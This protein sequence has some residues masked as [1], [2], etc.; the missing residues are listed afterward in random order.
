MSDVFVVTSR[1]RQ[2]SVVVEI[3]CRDMQAAESHIKAQGI[4]HN[5][6]ITYDTP[7]CRV[8]ETSD[9]RWEVVRRAF[10]I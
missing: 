4:G 2:N 5:A 6:Q 1:V 10:V 9:A 3:V 7:R 8:Y